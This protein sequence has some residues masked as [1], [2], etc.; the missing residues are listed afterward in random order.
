[1]RSYTLRQNIIMNG[2]SLSSFSRH[3]KLLY[4]FQLFL[5]KNYIGHCP[6]LI[7]Q[8]LNCIHQ[9]KNIIVMQKCYDLFSLQPSILKN[10]EWCIINNFPKRSQ[11]CPLPKF[12]QEDIMMIE[13]DTLIIQ[14]QGVILS[15]QFEPSSLQNLLRILIRLRTIQLV[16]PLLQFPQLLFRISLLPLKL[17]QR[18]PL[19]P[20]GS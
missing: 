16:R 19:I 13:D 4:V 18:L 7:S 2:G 12:T 11:I 14:P 1:M 8:S 3:M 10:I 20:N 17:N 9:L 15:R 6:V 5:A